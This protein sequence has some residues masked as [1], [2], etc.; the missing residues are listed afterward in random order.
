MRAI[1][2]GKGY[3]IRALHELNIVDKHRP[4]IQQDFAMQE[5]HIDQQIESTPEGLVILPPVHW[6]S[7]AAAKDEDTSENSKDAVRLAVRSR[8]E[9]SKSSEAGR[10]E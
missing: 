2:W 9:K 10:S 1:L 4:L 7:E 8:L 3:L 5:V 6:S